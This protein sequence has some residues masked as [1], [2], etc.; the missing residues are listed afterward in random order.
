MKC[1]YLF[2]YKEKVI[3]ST[4]NNITKSLFLWINMLLWHINPVLFFY[5]GRHF[6]ARMG[7]IWSCMQCKLV[8][9]MTYKCCKQLVNLRNNFLERSNCSPDILLHL[10]CLVTVTNSFDSGIICKW[11]STE[12]SLLCC[13][14]QAFHDKMHKTT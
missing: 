14:W 3:Y 2:A 7:L 5:H 10:K 11:F 1:T 13:T 8:A 12:S 6:P 4:A 9:R